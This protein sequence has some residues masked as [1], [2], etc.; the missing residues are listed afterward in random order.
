MKA[1]QSDRV[2]RIMTGVV[3]FVYYGAWVVAALFLIVAPALK[4]LTPDL[5]FDPTPR[6][7]FQVTLP[8]LGAT[9]VSQWDV[10]SRDIALWD[11]T[12]GLVLP[13]SQLPAWFGLASFLALV[14][15]FVLV[16]DL[17]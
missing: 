4:K 12:A 10:G 17:V 15:G 7:V 8:E 6:L 16:L 13:T 9:A 1:H 11:V 2:V 5:L 14:M 3:S